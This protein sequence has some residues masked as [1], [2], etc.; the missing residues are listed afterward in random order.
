M[1]YAL[2]LALL[3][4][5]NAARAADDLISVPDGAKEEEVKRGG[6]LHSQ[7]PIPSSGSV[8]VYLAW[9]KKLIE[10]GRKNLMSDIAYKTQVKAGTRCLW[11]P[12]AFGFRQS[13]A[14]QYEL[15][16]FAG[17]ARRITHVV[18]YKMN[19]SYEPAGCANDA[20]IRDFFKPDAVRNRN[21]AL[22]FINMLN[23]T[24]PLRIEHANP[25]APIT[26]AVRM[27]AEDIQKELDKPERE[28]L[29]SYVNR[30]KTQKH[31]IEGELTNPL[32]G[33]TAAPDTGDAK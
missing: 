9:A 5:A 7:D 22:Q 29:R 20:K 15:N 8:E 33:N 24:C 19:F 18:F 21:G 11:F 2:I 14:N 3:F 13:S 30:G 23:N 6:P 10:S 4:N 28:A 25:Q 1:K 17:T 26:K 16:C 32:R 27:S 12:G 31:G